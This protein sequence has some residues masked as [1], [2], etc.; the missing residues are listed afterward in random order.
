VCGGPRRCFS[1]QSWPGARRPAAAASIAAPVESREHHFTASLPAGWHLARRSLTPNL[2]NPVEILSAGT[3]PE[4]RARDGD[5]A[6]MPVGAIEQMGPRDALVTI[7]ERSGEPRFPDRPPRFTLPG[8]AGQSEAIP[9]AHTATRLDDY[10]FGFRDANR[11]FHVL[12]VLGH[13]APPE[14]RAEALALL[15]SLRFEPGPV[16]VGL[17]PDLAVPYE[18]TS[19]RLAWQMP[20]PPW[21]RYDWRMTSVQ[22]ER[23]MLGTFDLKRT[24]P[25]GNCTPR[26]AIDALPA[27][28]AFIYLLE[29]EDLAP[30]WKERIPE[31]TGP[32]TLGPERPYECMGPSRMV[33]WRDHGRAFQA[34]VYLGARASDRLRRDAVSILNSIRPA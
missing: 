23:L 11:G 28:G 30:R 2:S 1:S 31:R 16:G 7:F 13:D 17:D 20:V 29:Y 3:M 19:A 24:P 15:D 25:D 34:N 14:R 10:W 12:V 33:T 32:L 6:H 26:A 9:C 4:L 27:T 22:G 8:R 5:C 21:R 18:D